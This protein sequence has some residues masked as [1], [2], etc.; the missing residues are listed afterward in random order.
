[1]KITKEMASGIKKRIMGLVSFKIYGV[2]FSSVDT[3][4][5]SAFLGLKTLA[6]YNN[7]Y[8]VQTSIIGFMTILTS[9]ITAGIGNKMVTNSR[10]DNYRD[11][12]KVTFMN[13]WL[14]S[15]CAVCLVCLYQHF[16]TW[17]VG[18]DLTFPIHTMLLMVAY[19]FL[20]RVSTITFTYREAAGLWWED[21]FRPL[22]AAAVNLAV[23]LLLV[24]IIGVDGVIISTILCTIFINIPWGAYILFKNYFYKKPWEYYRQLFIC[25]F[26]TAFVATVTWFLCSLLPDTGFFVMLLKGLICVV[27]SNLLFVAAY[28]K[29]KE[30]KES[31]EILFTMIVKI[32]SRK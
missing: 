20:P 3:I 13:A 10:E 8:Y 32:K 24:R 22:V 14:S 16:M 25:I 12:M 29:K 28:C 2:I 26:V 23:N 7:Y 27:I 30:F 31:K 17:W 5:I 18:E 21:R 1:M 9:S 4:V 6:I 15:F 11:F 19:F